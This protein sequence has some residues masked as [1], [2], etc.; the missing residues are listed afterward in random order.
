MSCLV[1]NRLASVVP[2]IAGIQN[3][4]LLKSA[5]VTESHG[6]LISQEWRAG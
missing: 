4:L 6:F 5:L 1:L 2:G 3:S